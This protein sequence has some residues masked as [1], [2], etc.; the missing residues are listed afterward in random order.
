[1]KV[2][3]EYCGSYVEADENMKCPLCMGELGSAVLQEQQRQEQAE[4]LEQQ[5][6]VEEQAQ[7]A[8]DE[9]I[10]EVIQGIT[11]VATAFVA[12]RATSSDDEDMQGN[13][14]PMPP[15]GFR[16]PDGTRGHG[17]HGRSDGRGPNG[18]GGHERRDGRGPGG[19]GGPGPR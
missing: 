10:S 17:G 13:R 19:P 18:I 2:I 1:M 5:R 3:C 14:P 16:P 6:E 11:S 15:E 7:E 4:A 12:G 9:H 8:K